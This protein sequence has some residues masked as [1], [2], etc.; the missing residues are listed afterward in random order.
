MNKKKLRIELELML[1]NKG[2]PLKPFPWKFINIFSKLDLY[3]SSV[4]GSV[5]SLINRSRLVKKD[6]FGDIWGI[7]NL[8][9]KT[10]PKNREEKEFLLKAKKFYVYL[11]KIEKLAIRVIDEE[12]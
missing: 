8:L 4:E 7:E 12:E 3:D 6:E 11:Q 1:K 2:Y 5:S 9:K 10:N